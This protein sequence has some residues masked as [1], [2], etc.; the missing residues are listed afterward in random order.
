MF[1]PNFIQ[2]MSMTPK[3]TKQRMVNVEDTKPGG[4][5][6]GSL[7]KCLISGNG[8]LARSDLDPLCS[9]KAIKKEQ[10]LRLNLK[11]NTY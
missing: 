4:R 9:S 8:L 7:N 11:Q 5:T 3:G 1:T 2:A 10:S 6:S